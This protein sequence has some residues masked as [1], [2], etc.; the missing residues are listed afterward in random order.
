MRTVEL[1]GRKMDTRALAH[2][3]IA[4]ALGFPDYYGANLDALHDCLGDMPPTR[5][6]LKHPQAMRNALGSYALEL[7][8]VFRDEAG[9][10]ADFQ[11]T[12]DA[13]RG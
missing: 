1:D 6:V 12:E 2:R 3:H 13:G 10:R 9:E 5:V 8:R 4:A 7:V 11:F